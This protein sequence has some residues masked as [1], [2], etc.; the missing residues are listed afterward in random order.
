MLRILGFMGRLGSMRGTGTLSWST[1]VCT[2]DCPPP[3]ASYFVPSGSSLNGGVV[4][5]KD[6]GN[7]FMSG[8]SPTIG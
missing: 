4:G 3:G 5:S 1:S 6:G 8:L 2:A 7:L